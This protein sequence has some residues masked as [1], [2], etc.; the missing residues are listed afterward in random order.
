TEAEKG[1]ILRELRWDWQGKAGFARATPWRSA[2]Q[3]P[4]EGHAPRGVGRKPSLR[5][6][7]DGRFELMRVEHCDSAVGESDAPCRGGSVS[8]RGEHQSVPRRDRVRVVAA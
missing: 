2:K 1:V 8:E 4:R 7:S 6:R 5:I 3:K